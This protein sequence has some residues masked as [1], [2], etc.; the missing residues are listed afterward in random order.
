MTNHKKNYDLSV[1]N[2]RG[3]SERKDNEGTTAIVK[4]IRIIPMFVYEIAHEK[5]K[6]HR[7]GLIIYVFRNKKRAIPTLRKL[8]LVF[9]K[10]NTGGK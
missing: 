8:L 10:I 1:L 5:N 9:R 7:I 3:T 2:D 6:T 4:R